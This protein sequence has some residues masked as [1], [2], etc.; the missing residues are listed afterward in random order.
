MTTLQIGSLSISPPLMLAP[1]SGVTDSAFRRIVRRASGRSVGLMLTEFISVEALTRDNEKSFRMMRFRPEERPIAIQIFGSDADRMARA[2]RLVEES[3]ADVLDINCGCPVP[4]VVKRGG[5]CELMRQ[6]ERL[7]RILQAVRREVSIPVTLKMRSG[8]DEASR[9][10]AEVAAIAEAAGLAMVT[11][12]GRTRV[13]LYHGE[14][15]WSV[16]PALR[17]RV[18]IPVVGSGDVLTAADALCREHEFAPD[19]VMIGRGALANPWIFRQ[20]EELRRGEPAYGPSLEER[21][22]TMHTYAAYLEEDHAPIAVA[23]RLRQFAGRL[24]KGLRSGAVLRA[25][26]NEA[27]SK[28]AILDLLCRFAE[29]EGSPPGE[30]PCAVEKATAQIA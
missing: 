27:R 17:R 15:D 18:S 26:I 8:W 25:G 7:S 1:M 28:Q 5:G 4:K 12:H 11:I 3:G 14:A 29:A 2:A 16:I 24:T 9:N 10:A 20:I 23:A 6:P 30:E 21:L 19:G 22:A 13:Q